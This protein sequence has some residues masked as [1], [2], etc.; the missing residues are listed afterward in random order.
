MIASYIAG[1]VNKEEYKKYFMQHVSLL[2]NNFKQDVNVGFKDGK[3]GVI[4]PETKEFK[5]FSEAGLLEQG[6]HNFSMGLTVGAYIDRDIA[7]A[8][9]TIPQL[10]KIVKNIPEAATWVGDG[11]TRGEFKYEPTLPEAALSAFQGMMVNTFGNVD[12]ITAYNTGTRA[13]EIPPHIAPL[14]S[15]ASANIGI[16]VNVIAKQIGQESSFNHG[17]VSHTGVKGLIQMTR[18][19]AKGLGF[20]PDRVRSNNKADAPYQ[21]KAYEAYMGQLMKRYNGDVKLAVLA[22][23]SGEGA[24]DDYKNKGKMPRSEGV[25]YVKKILG[26]D[27]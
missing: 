12:E 16:P 3:I 8:Q 25:H 15:E 1:N 18:A 2:A 22:Y 26:V 9:L 10:E 21:M 20:D 19:T 5:T 27:L 14:L 17:A 7:A 4:N 6:L 11:L 23:N 13:G 24:A